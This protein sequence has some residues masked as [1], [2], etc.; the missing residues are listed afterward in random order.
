MAVVTCPRCNQKLDVSFAHLQ[1]WVEC[2]ACRVQFT[3]MSETPG[4]TPALSTPSPLRAPS[5]QTG[6]KLVLAIEGPDGSGKS[7]LIRFIKDFV[8][9]QGRTFTWVARRGPYASTEV[10]RMTRVLKDEK[11]VL[12]PEADFLIRVARDC[13]RARLA[14]QAPPGVVLLDRFVINDLSM[15]RSAGLD[16]GP[17][18]GLLQGIKTQGQVDATVL[19]RCPFEL[20]SARVNLRDRDLHV[21]ESRTESF[22]RKMAV[23]LEEEFERGI[24]T[25]LKWPVDNSHSLAGAEQ[26]VTSYLLPYLR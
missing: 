14:A 3:P 26:E 13:Q 25:G 17:F 16:P 23:Y 9:Q 8:E 7:S 10:E 11:K 1:Q 21:R 2:P 20:A 24:L 18:L 12:T 5:N 22:L 15:I 19:V 4:A 6:R